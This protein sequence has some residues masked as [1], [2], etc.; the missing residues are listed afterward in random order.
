MPRRTAIMIR[1]MIDTCCGKVKDAE[2]IGRNYPLR[3]ITL[4][5]RRSFIL[6]VPQLKGPINNLDIHLTSI[7]F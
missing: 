3:E 1:V 2:F 5:I 4:L 7:H 6:Y